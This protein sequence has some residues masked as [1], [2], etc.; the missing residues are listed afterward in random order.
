MYHYVRED[1]TN[2]PYSKH[3]NIDDFIKE[4]SF[5]KRNHNF[6]NVTE[7][8]NQ[9]NYIE[10]KNSIILTFDDG[11]KD[12]LNV[13][14]I[15]KKYNIKA[16]F[17]I[18][19]KPHLNEELLPVH[20]AHLITSTYGEESLELLEKALSTLNIDKF[21]LENKDE[22]DLFKNRY[23]NHSDRDSIKNF[24]KIINYY[25]SIGLRDLI[26]NQILKSKNIKSDFESFYLNKEEIK[27]ISSLGFEIGSHGVSHT[28]MSRLS[29][30][31][32]YYEMSES[33]TF[34]EKII[35]KKITSFCYPYGRKNSYNSDSIE[36][37]S[38]AKYQNAISVDSRDITLEDI[39][40]NIY[41][42]PRYDCNEIESVLNFQ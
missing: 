6:L 14:E 28:V 37:L 34:L 29:K 32:Q 19:I 11:L 5:M 26:L 33:K 7:A 15:L 10:N 41:E 9:E 36:I 17:Y 23:M 2:A 39:K 30:K 3:K 4:I 25:G 1:I 31:E 38:K 35:R 42:I 24:K 16:T 22:K 12:H 21:S 20:K 8:I 13:A 27:H 40:K 18:P